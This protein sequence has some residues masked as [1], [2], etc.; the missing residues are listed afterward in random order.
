MLFVSCILISCE[1]MVV[2]IDNEQEAGVTNKN[3]VIRISNVES[4]WNG[5]T[6]RA[7]V[8]I[9]EVCTRLC[10]AVYKNGERVKNK[11]QKVSDSD[12][13][14]FSLQLDPGT[15]QLLAL[16]HSGIADPSTTNPER[17]QFVNPSASNG[18]GFTDTFYYYG[19]FVVDEGGTQISINMV[20]ATS[21]FRLKTNDGKPSNV[22]EF[23][24]LYT[25]G[26]GTLDATTG[27]GCVNSQQALLV[28][29][30][31][32]QA[33]EPLTFEMYTFLHQETG[34]VTFTVKALG[35]SGILY[36]KTFKNIQMKRNCITQY[37]GD[38]FTDDNNEIEGEPL[39]PEVSGSS[40]G[41]VYV[42]PEWDNIY[43]FTF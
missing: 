20:R 6:T 13:G 43:R 14:T 17:I 21:M 32:T 18:T 19:D 12:F 8:S 41:T 40:S 24:F 22:K 9:D 39:D 27:F 11:N 30:S 25:G 7:L 5:A 42:D 29:V 1:K 26:S 23:Q 15:Y 38:Y 10:F 36:T 4:G 35:N 16:G 37:T 28:S 34:S 33:G 2:E 31:D 3:V